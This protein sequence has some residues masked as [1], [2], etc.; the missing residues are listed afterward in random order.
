M[1]DLTVS[2][3]N[4]DDAFG[5]LEKEC[6]DIVR[7]LLVQT[8]THI[9]ARTPQY[10]G[11]FAASWTWTYS[12]SNFKDRSNL[13]PHGDR[14]SR[15]LEAIFAN[16]LDLRR[17]GDGY[18][19]TIANNASRG[20]DAEFKLG[21]MV[22]FTNGVD[23]GEGPYSVT[24][25]EYPDYRLRP[26]NRPGRPVART[27]DQVQSLYGNDIRRTTAERFKSLRLGGAADNS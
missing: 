3:D 15:T 5:D 2:W 8:W 23:H 25:E 9:L 16:P 6:T 1:P 14:P 20:K 21:R 27:L 22:Y 12:P 10:Y 17:K 19:V 4:L 18:A 7:G 26:V 13:L 24:V 11:G